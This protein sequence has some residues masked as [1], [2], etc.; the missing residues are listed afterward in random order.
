[1][2]FHKT[3]QSL[4][5]RNWVCNA[6][7]GFL[8]YLKAPRPRKRLIQQLKNPSAHHM[9]TF[10]HVQKPFKLYTWEGLPQGLS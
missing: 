8:K 5:H 1:L 9:Q 6:R 10:Y 2:K 7:Q 4:H 3:Q